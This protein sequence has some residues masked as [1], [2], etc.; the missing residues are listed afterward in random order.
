MLTEGKTV[1]V[2]TIDISESGLRLNSNRNLAV[3]S[4]HSIALQLPD[5]RSMVQAKAVVRCIE[6]MDAP[7]SYKVGLQFSSMSPSSKKALKD[8]LNQKTF[9]GKF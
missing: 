2:Q 7:E 5:S 9:H 1:G 4:E 6:K 3:G 8:F